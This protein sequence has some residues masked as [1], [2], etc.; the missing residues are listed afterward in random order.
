MPDAGINRLSN[1]AL[2]RNRIITTIKIPD[3]DRE[4]LQW[5]GFGPDTY[6]A[7]GPPDFVFPVDNPGFYIRFFDQDGE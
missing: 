1:I 6:P 7:G 5:M 4:F 3:D 2:K